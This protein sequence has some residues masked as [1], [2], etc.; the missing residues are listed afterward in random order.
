MFCDEVLD[1]VEEIAAG[2]LTPDG[3]IA[4]HL[5]TCPNCAA[6]LA[7]ARQLEQML[8]A[9]PVPSAPAQFTARTM[10]RV[11]RARWR[12]EQVVDVG[13]NAALV[14]IVLGVISG[15]WVFLNQIG[16]ASVGN[17]AVSLFSTAAITLAERV[18]PRLPLY[19]GATALLVA[20][21][22]FWWWAERDA[23]F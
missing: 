19:V 12:S 11:R 4:D 5:A 18:A 15:I 21:L 3:R 23:T 8:R 2:E 20:A 13:F 7:D 9:R 14:L 16:L 6:A 22:A 17:D 1:A 10:S